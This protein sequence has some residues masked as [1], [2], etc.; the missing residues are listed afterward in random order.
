MII[1]IE[2]DNS[3]PLRSKTFH[4]LLGTLAYR[5]E[6]GGSI[7][8]YFLCHSSRTLVMFSG[9]LPLGPKMYFGSMGSAAVAAAAVVS[10]PGRVRFVVSVVLLVLFSSLSTSSPSSSS[11]SATDTLDTREYQ[12]CAWLGIR[13]GLHVK[14]RL[15]FLFRLN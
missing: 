3:L 14:L 12:Q 6:H 4:G 8:G 15:L 10:S 7:L 2:N 11:S 1:N 9:S 13:T 5:N